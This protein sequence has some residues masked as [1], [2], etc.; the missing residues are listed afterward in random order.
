MMS[1]AMPRAR[2]P[3]VPGRIFKKISARFLEAGVSRISMM[4]TFPPRSFSFWTPATDR[5]LE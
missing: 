4:M 5:W 1:F 3:S 2:A